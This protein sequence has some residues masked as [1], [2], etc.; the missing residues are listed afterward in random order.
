MSETIAD[1]KAVVNIKTPTA[2]SIIHAVFAETS[3]AQHLQRIHLYLSLFP[4]LATSI[5]SYIPIFIWL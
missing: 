3:E 5:D 2:P 1:K 4:M